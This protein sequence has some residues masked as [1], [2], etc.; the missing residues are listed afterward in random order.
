[1]RHGV[2]GRKLNRTSSHRKA[3]RRNMVQSLIEHGRIKTTLVKAK[4][5]RAF[6][7]RLFTLAIDGSLA[8]R[9][10]A[11][12]LLNDRQI[13]PRDRQADYDRMSD[14]D[15]ARTHRSRSGRR[16]RA[17]TTRP[18]VE[19]TSESVVNRLFTEIGPA[20]KARIADRGS[21]GGYTRIIKLAEPRLGDAAPTAILEIVSAEDA[22]RTGRT[23]T[24]RRRRKAEAR[25]ALFAG[26]V[27]STAAAAK[28]QAEQAPAEEAAPEGDS[29]ED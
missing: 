26:G 10:R 21:A 23:D 18:G 11:T 14:E 19:F 2:G 20:L 13:V 7:E 12:A 5:V 4:D 17:A 1:M 8:A 6:A 28:A 3:M 29:T 25:Y 9:Q 16:Y 27:T 22:P 24:N 15:R